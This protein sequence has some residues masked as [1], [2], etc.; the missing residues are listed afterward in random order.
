MATNA[1]TSLEDPSTGI[2]KNAETNL[3]S[4]ITDIGANITTKQNQVTQ[5]TTTLTN[6]MAQADAMLSTLEQ[7]Y[8]SINQLFQAEQ[9]AEQELTL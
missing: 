1:L 7:Q 6:Q 8:D 5:M 2:V 9:T 4:Q 3:Q